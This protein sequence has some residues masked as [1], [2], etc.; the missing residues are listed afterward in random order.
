MFVRYFLFVLFLL[1]YLS[2]A[3][4][5]VAGLGKYRIGFTK[6]DS[7]DATAFTEQDQS[8]V[9]GTIALPCT[10]IRTFTAANATVAGVPITNLSLFFYDN[11]LFKL[12][13]DYSD[14]L[15]EVFLQQHGYG[16][17]SPARRFSLCTSE[18]DKPMLVWNESWLNADLL[19]MV[20]QRKGYTVDC[21][22]E[23]GAKL[24]IAS[25]RFTALSSDCELKPIDS[26]MEEFDSRVNR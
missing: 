3:Q 1:P 6:P 18:R 8:Y 5:T 25:Q 11:T 4:S 22:P 16:V 24:I 23:E 19:A 2:G 12:A 9:K 17:G 26:F 10:H 13:C 15:K 21:Q 20:V 7:L 14:P